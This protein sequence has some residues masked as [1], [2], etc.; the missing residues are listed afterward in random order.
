VD[1]L[2]D[3]VRETAAQLRAEGADVLAVAADIT[4]PSQVEAMVA[5]VESELGPVDVLVNNAGTFSV[6]APVWEADAEKWFRDVRTNLYGTFLVCRAVV[7]RMV[8]HQLHS[9]GAGYVINIV[10][11]G[12]V[13]DPHP[14]ST[15]Y[16]SSKAGSMRLTEGLAAE[17]RE[18]GIP[19]FAVAPPAILTD[20]T[21]FILEDPGGKKWRPGFEQLFERGEDYPPEAV[22]DL[23][24]KLTSGQADAL[25]G[26][27]LLVSEDL[28]ELVSRTDEI[29]DRDLL[30]L[31]IRKV[32]G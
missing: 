27:Y 28:D 13:G 19:V 4:D 25:T 30:T 20:M 8:A 5:Q 16:A 32:E 2:A 9:G 22:A 26:R 7:R 1:I 14:Y 3:R 21:R 23:C 6:I 10:S 11:S 15:S 31:R 18:H 12:G 17:L 24:V 29:V